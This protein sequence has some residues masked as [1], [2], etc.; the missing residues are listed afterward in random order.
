V[1]S[2]K[3]TDT[4]IVVGNSQGIMQG[5]VAK[6]EVVS[7]INDHDIIVRINGGYR[8]GGDDLASKLGRPANYWSFSHFDYILYER[9]KGFH[10]NAIELRLNKRLEYAEMGGYNGDLKTYNSLISDYG[11]GRPSTGLITIH[12]ITHYCNSELSVIGFDFFKTNNWYTQTCG[13]PCHDWQR[14][15]EYVSSMSKV[16]IL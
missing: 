12:Y 9:W 15:K 5:D 11:H 10:P 7:I 1:I 3:A 4:I 8:A 16:T 14:E 2:K 13:A 6:P